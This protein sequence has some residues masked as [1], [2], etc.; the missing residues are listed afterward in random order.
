M[1]AITTD[2]TATTMSAVELAGFGYEHLRHV[3]RPVRAVGPGEVRV[4]MRAAS[5]NFR[6]HVVITGGYGVPDAALPFVPVS[7][8]AGDVVEVGEGVERLKV[9]DRVTTLMTRDWIAGPLTPERHAAQNGGP[10]DGVL[11]ESVV[12]PERALSRFADHLDY[13]EAACL[14]IA[15]LTAWTALTKGGLRPGQTVLATGSGNV[16]LFTLQLGRLWGARVILTSGDVGTRGPKLRRLGAHAVVDYRDPDWPEHVVA[17]NDGRG[18]DLV[19]ET[20]G[21]AALGRTLRA[22]RQ[23]AFIGLI[24]LLGSGTAAEDATVPL[25]MKNVRLRG[26]ITGCR[27]DYEALQRAVAL[28]ALRPV[29]DSRFPLSDIRVA[30]DHAFRGRP[31]GKVVV[32]VA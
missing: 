15:A 24:G 21:A 8:G 32:D 26:V 25:V 14:P 19:I 6:D 7:D 22:V 5:L 13:A 11:A 20:A 9:G 3:R 2:V 12:L 29:I 31:F 28:H 4:A 27:D 17:A 16:S 30:F 10:L 1:N 18:V 23:G